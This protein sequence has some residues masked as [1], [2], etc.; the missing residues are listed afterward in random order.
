ML[1]EL[2]VENYILIDK[3]SI[4]FDRGFNVLTGETGAGKS[5]VIDA[6]G[7][8][9]GDRATKDC[10]RYG[11]ELAIIE[12]IFDIANRE[13]IIDTLKQYGIDYN[14]YNMLIISREIHSSGRSTSRVNGRAVTLSILKDITSNIIDIHGQHEHQSLLESE[15]HFELIDSLNSKEITPLLLKI[16]NEYDNLVKFNNKLKELTLDERERERKLD[17]LKFQF[18]EI[19]NSNLKKD[20]FDTIT[21]RYNILSNTEDIIK[22]VDKI[23]NTL[24]NYEYRETSVIDLVNSILISLQSISV[25]DKKFLE[26]HQTVQA[27]VYQ[28]QDLYRELRKYGENLEFNPEEL[29]EL[30]DRL[31]IINKLKRKYGDD[32]SQILDY[33]EN[34][35]VEINSLSNCDLEIDNY[36]NKITDTEKVLYSL[37]DE[38]SVN[39]KITSE[40]LERM[41][42]N[43]LNE[44]NM[45]NIIFKVNFDKFDY[46]TPNGIDKIEFLIS[47]NIGEP[48][49]SLSKIVSGGEMSR[50]MLAFKSI[51]ADVDRI[52]SLIFDEIDTGISGRTAQVVG[53]K[54][55]KISKEHQILCIT[56]LPQIAAMAD[57]HFLINKEIINN[58]SITNIVKLSYDEQIQELSRLLGGVNLTEITK[59]HAKETLDLAKAYKGNL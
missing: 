41:I 38:L 56:H 9:L 17:L 10:I 33:K 30:E 18:D 58:K 53:E 45:S 4:S 42:S 31:D 32:I 20:E 49:K 51:L 11:E 59:K 48:L 8:L 39:R 23:N 55:A 37:C 21:E 43:E 40:K 47:T 15:K 52:S 6:I 35:E 14:D 46:F 28:L 36:K 2:S 27:V 7:L 54:I 13:E 1:L 16:K 57:T 19:N 34:I 26:H 3:L 44:L 25:F 22:N 29:K 24:N 5:I 50:I 12:G